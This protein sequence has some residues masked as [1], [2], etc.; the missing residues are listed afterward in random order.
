M[1]RLVWAFAG[2][3][4]Q[5]VGNLVP[6][7]IWDLAGHNSVLTT[8]CLRKS[9]AIQDLYGQALLK[10]PPIGWANV[11]HR[12]VNLP[13]TITIFVLW[14]YMM[15]AQTTILPP[16]HLLCCLTVAAWYLFPMLLQ[17]RF[18]ASNRIM[19]EHCVSLITVLSPYIKLCPLILKAF[20]WACQQHTF[21]WTSCFKPHP[22]KS[23][24][25]HW[26]RKSNSYGTLECIFLAWNE[27]IS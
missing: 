18:Q 2:L 24:M 6:R 4:Y 21:E 10:F 27:W 20:K 22:T 19:R 14:L 23:L 13:C 15:L 11:I 17:T 26:L 12:D 8:H 7:L 3:T 9:M 25:N 16:P 1:R 5:I